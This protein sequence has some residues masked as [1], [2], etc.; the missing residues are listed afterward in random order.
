MANTTINVRINKS[1]RTKI[2]VSLAVSYR[3][4]RLIIVNMNEGGN[5]VAGHIGNRIVVD[6][7]L[8]Q[9]LALTGSFDLGFHCRAVKLGTGRLT[10]QMPGGAA[11][12][13][14]SQGGTIYCDD[15]GIAVIDIELVKENTWIGTG[16]NIWTTT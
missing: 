3:S 16:S 7:S 2:Y 13:D 10:L 15:S 6:N 14:S 9:I 5:I 4:S 1:G 12:G 11:I 8:A